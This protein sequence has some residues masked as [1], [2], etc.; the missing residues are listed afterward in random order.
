MY[1]GGNNRWVPLFLLLSLLKERKFVRLEDIE[2]NI[3]MY[4]PFS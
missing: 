3:Y 1:L 2:I 4:M